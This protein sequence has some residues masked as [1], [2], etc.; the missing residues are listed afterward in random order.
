VVFALARADLRHEWVLTVC[1]VLAIAAV[2]APLLLMFGIKYGTIETL[3]HRLVQ[4]PRNREIRPLTGASFE[5]EWFE[6]VR[7]RKEVAFV[8]PL[9]RQIAA[10]LEASPEGREDSQTLDII[11]TAP[12]DPLL[13]E[14]LAPVPGPGQC[15]LSNTAA[16]EL[17]VET[18]RNLVVTVKRLQGNRYESARAILGVVGV[19]AP[20]AGLNKTIYTTLEFLEGVEQYKDGLAVPAYGWPGNAP[21]A[22]P[23]FDGLVLVVPQE[24]DK[25]QEVGL[26][27]NTGFNRIE[28]LKPGQARERLGFSIAAGGAAYLVHNQSKPAGQESVEAVR[29][30]LRGLGAHLLPWV[31]GIKAQLDRKSTRLNSSHNPASRMPSSA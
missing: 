23:V 26:I 13:R 20:A 9:T 30:R 1:M 3:R 2:L 10:T 12:G 4:D 21:L 22:Y 24:L 14:S 8:I 25:L 31:A 27:N 29:V 28:R 17:G 15:V 6:T 19:L 18:G 7:G 5:R 11:P 16:R